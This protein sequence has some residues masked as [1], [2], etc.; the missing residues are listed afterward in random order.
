MLDRAPVLRDR[1]EMNDPL[2]DMLAMVE[3]RS[4]LSGRLVA[5][6]T[7][8]VLFP[9]PEKIK[10]SALLWGECWLMMEGAADPIRLEAGDVIVVN[11]QRSFTLTSDV[12]VDP[13]DAR[14]LFRDAPDNVARI[15]VGDEVS[16][17]GGHIAL[18]AVRADLLMNVLPPLIHVRSARSEAGVLRWLLEQ[19]VGELGAHRPGGALASSHLAQLMFVQVLRAYLATSAHSSDASWLRALA[20]DQI[21]P[22]L[23]LI[24]ANPSRSWSLEELSRASAMSRTTFAARF[25]EVSGVSPVAY[26]LAWR[27]RLAERALRHGDAPIASVAL[28]V[29]Y[30]SES[31]FSNAF[32]RSS[33]MS[34]RSYRSRLRMGQTDEDAPA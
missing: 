9:P 3:A 7:W 5:G 24:H 23:R 29:G 13:V 20:D 19:L 18:D 4:L 30:T 27:M 6:G 22:A 12:D 8:G 32:K 25:K 2:S 14:E 11:G 10:F 1:P 28:S 21:A 33:G 16:L 34:P 15:G 26:L 17:F 31:A